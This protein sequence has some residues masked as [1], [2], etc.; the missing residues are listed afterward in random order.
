[1]FWFLDPAP[2]VFTIYVTAM[3]TGSQENQDSFH[4]WLPL[5]EFLRGETYF[6]R[7]SPYTTILEPGNAREIITVSAYDDRNG[8]FYT[9][10]GRG[11]TRQGLIKPDFAAPGVSIS[12]ALGKGTGTSL[13]AAISAGA[14]AQFLQWAIVEENQPWVGN[15]EI[16]NYLIRGARRQSVSEATYRIYPNKEE[17]FGK[18][19]ISGTFDI[20]AG[21]D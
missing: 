11:Y 1:M 20:L 17:G 7:P 6:L 4:M 12:T 10:S 16:R 13:S 8:S 2:G 14:A 3:G 19:S 18:L 15:R 5:K 21:T 9:S